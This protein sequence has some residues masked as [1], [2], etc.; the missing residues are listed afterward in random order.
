VARCGGFQWLETAGGGRGPAVIRSV[1]LVYLRV[2]GVTWFWD[3]CGS[4]PV[5]SARGRP[6]GCAGAVPVVSAATGGAL[7]SLNLAVPRKQRG[8]IVPL[9]PRRVARGAARPRPGRGQQS[10]EV[11]SPVPELRRPGAETTR[12]SV[13]SIAGPAHRP[14]A[15]RIGV[16][17]WQGCAAAVV[18]EAVT[19]SVS[20]GFT[21]HND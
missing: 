4:G 19:L 8:Q 16:P 9:L 13:F 6:Q 1:S 11:R 18:H 5:V 17:R 20:R 21:R 10:G 2:H 3:G 14:D 7:L 12:P 15:V